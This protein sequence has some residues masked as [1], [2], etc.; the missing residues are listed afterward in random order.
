M[1]G[2]K[3]VVMPKS[4]TSID[5]SLPTG[6]PFPHIFDKS[7][8][9][10]NGFLV[11]DTTENSGNGVN[12]VPVLTSLQSSH[13]MG[14]AIKN[15]ASRC[16]KINLNKLHRFRDAGLENDELL[17]TTEELISLYECYEEDTIC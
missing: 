17:E 4:I 2:K 12:S 9:S 5:T 6:C 7:R 8:I 1:G 15:I 11:D 13:E 10:S 16:G 14:L 3:H